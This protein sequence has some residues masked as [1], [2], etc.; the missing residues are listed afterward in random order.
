MARVLNPTIT[1][2]LPAMES[3]DLQEELQGLADVASYS[4]DN[5]TDVSALDAS[6]IAHDV[7][8]PAVSALAHNTD[9]ITDPAV[10][11]AYRSLLKHST[12]LQGTYMTKVL[13]SITSA[14]IAQVEATARDVNEEDQQTV[15]VHKMPLEMYAFLLNW[16]VTAAEKVKATG[17]DDAPAP[18]P[19]PKRGRGGKASTSRATAKKPREEWSWTDQIPATLALIAKVLRLKVQK[20]WQTSAEKDVFIK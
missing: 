11:D 2:P 12:S 1:L 15:M 6:S 9:S 14:Y 5:E 7:L 17:E 18:A 16:F 19:K 8:E 3:F 20:I 4:F 13:D 10:F